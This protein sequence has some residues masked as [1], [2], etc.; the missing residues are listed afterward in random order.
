MNMKETQQES[1]LSI[2]K[3]KNQD[4]LKLLNEM[5]VE[6]E[7]RK[8]GMATDAFIKLT[9]DK[10]VKY[11]EEIKRDMGKLEILNRDINELLTYAPDLS[12]KFYL[13]DIYDIEKPK[14]GENNLIISPVGSGKT[15][16]ITERLVV[17]GGKYLLLVSTQSLKDSL[18]PDNNEARKKYSNNMYTSKNITIYG[19][20]KY[21]IHVMTYAEFG[22]K[23][24]INNSFIKESKFSRIF[25]DEIHSLPAYIKY[26]GNKNVGL[27]HAQRLLFN[28]IKNVEVFYFTATK[29]HL[30]QA[31]RDRKGTLGA[32]KVFDYSKYPNIMQYLP[33]AVRE[34]NNV[35]QIR[36]Y[37]KDRRRSFE[38]Y[39]YKGVLFSKTISSMKSIEK[40]VREEG[41][42]PLILWSGNNSEHKMNE[43]QKKARLELLESNKIPEPYDFLIFNSSLQEGW[44]LKDNSI[45]LAIM[46]TTN[47]TEFTQALGRI[48][49]DVDLLI[50]RTKSRKIVKN[51]VDLVIP[52]GYIG[53]LLLP[54]DKENLAKEL[55]LIGRDG[56]PSGWIIVN[57]ILKESKVYNVKDM[58]KVVDG[59][60]Y[61]MTLIEYS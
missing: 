53:R 3:L 2:N 47:D 34:I 28:K 48:R 1:E 4:K 54:I 30:T 32:V 60:R 43:V 55:N 20:L 37:L 50:Y 31:E 18:A 15:T 40:I 29:D 38:Y 17:D 25:C 6:V 44:D 16:F 35:E 39:G 8:M 24:F 13:T 42:N 23:I 9:A 14:F 36:Q 10:Q 51:P 57:K 46:N 26:G 5:L 52:E 27:I 33:K 56:K 49:R 12:S 41:Y 22:E 19:D 45:K 58:Q 59:K 11:I 61:R 21:K 7:R